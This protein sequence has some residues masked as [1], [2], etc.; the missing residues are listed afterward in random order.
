MRHIQICVAGA[1]AVLAGALARAA[2]P[3]VAAVAAP[4]PSTYIAR[5]AA[6]RIPANAAAVVIKPLDGGALTWS[7]NASKPM[8]PASTMKLVTTYSALHLLGPAFT[9]RTE[10]L[11]EAPVLG[12]AL[13]GDLY[14]RG[15][16]DPKLVIEQLWLLVNRLRG[17]GIREIRGDVVLD[18]T[19]FEPLAHDPAEFDGAEGRA[20]NVGP[21][22]LL[23][24]FKS[25]AITFVPD[26]VAKVARV[27]VVPEVAGLKVPATIPA[28]E[29]G[30]GDWRGRLQADIND[31]MNIR[32]RGVYPMACGE[33]AIYL[34]ALEHTSY[35][36]AVFRALWER[37][38]GAWTG[39]VRDGVVPSGARLIAVQ[40]SPPLAMLIRDINKFSNNV[41]TQQLYLTMGAAGGE[42]GNPAR[43]GA[44]IRNLLS[45]RGLAMPELV[46]ENGCGLSRIERI[47]A[48][49][50]GNLLG[51]AWKS[52]WMPEL[53]SSLPI[54]GVDGTMK[55]RH[56]PPGVAHMK[57]GLLGDTR[58][59]AGYVLAA[60]GK[61]YVV[62]AFI[63][64]PN[65]SRGTGAHD[66]LIEWVYR[67]G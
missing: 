42:P 3:G 56:V 20:Y 62:V 21:D 47:S 40:D 48:G 31:P 51:D 59:V 1:L 39:K 45:T 9:F 12:E 30:C 54:A 26:P 66:A 38:G 2:E 16:G 28:I 41:M 23:V 64:H 19:L 34:G 43:G 27:I 5:L 18:K 14:V 63:N 46:L 15:G 50:L 57:T 36:S 65:A 61:R 60:S 44:A 25:I 7:A 11:S 24:N 29:G 37:Q 13:R 6:A 22:P 35:F 17:F 4:V 52:Q 10:M 8:N 55:A 33:R 32:L 49:S 58:A 67:V 53:M